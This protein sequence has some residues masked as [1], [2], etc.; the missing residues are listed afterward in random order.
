MSNPSYINTIV[1]AHG[2]SEYIF[3]ESIRANLRLPMKIFARNKGHS[4]IQVD[5]LNRYLSTG[6]FSSHRTLCK[7]IPRMPHEKDII[8]DSVVIFPIM[9]LDDT[10]QAKQYLDKT[11]FC[12][13]C[14]KNLIWPIFNISNLDDIL[15]QMGYEIDKNNKVRS[16]EKVFPANNGDEERARELLDQFKQN[17]NTNIDEFIEHCL[18]L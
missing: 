6:Y 7:A 13:N 4:S 15:I 12:N 9:D 3:C 14:F 10:P 8:N 18:N 16:Y 11:L 2:K 5:G 1:I 17:N